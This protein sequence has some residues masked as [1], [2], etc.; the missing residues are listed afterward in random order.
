MMVTLTTMAQQLCDESAASL[1][2]LDDL[3]HGRRNGEWKAELRAD[4]GL[5]DIKNCVTVA[6]SSLNMDG[7]DPIISM[8]TEASSHVLSSLDS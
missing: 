3:T 8:L 5:T 7:L 4:A 2:K 1:A 6:F